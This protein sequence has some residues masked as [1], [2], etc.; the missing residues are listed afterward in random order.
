MMTSKSSKRKEALWSIWAWEKN[1]LCVTRLPTITTLTNTDTTNQTAR[2]AGR[3]L[4]VPPAADRGVFLV[5][6][7]AD[8]TR[9]PSIKVWVKLVRSG[10][11]CSVHKHHLQPAL[12]QGELVFYT[13]C[14]ARITAEMV[15]DTLEDFHISFSHLINIYC[16]L[17]CTTVFAG[18]STLE[19]L[20]CLMW[21]F[22]A[23][24]FL[25]ETAG[26]SEELSLWGNQSH[27][28]QNLKDECIKHVMSPIWFA[29]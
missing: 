26:V 14:A 12:H 29:F 1:S 22:T 24:G 25:C 23:S 8:T 27:S 15:P 20:L 28:D 16:I 13:Q 4:R 9:P 11:C 5:C 17:D 3:V 6:A 2:E 19:S 18:I 10:S 7:L 21:D